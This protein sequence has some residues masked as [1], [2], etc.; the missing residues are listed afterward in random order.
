MFYYVTN[1]KLEVDFLCRKDDRLSAYQV[2]YNLSDP[3]T[4]QR[5]M[6]ALVKC[7]EELG[8]NEATIITYNETGSEQYKNTHITII[9]LWKFLLK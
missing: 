9:P 6:K 2:C 7:T 8:L 1:N 4:R 3:E 5:E